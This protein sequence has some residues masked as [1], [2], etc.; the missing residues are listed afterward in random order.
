MNTDGKFSDVSAI[1]QTAFLSHTDA[2]AEC[3]QCAV[4]RD[5]SKPKRPE[6]SAATV[7]DGRVCAMKVFV[8]SVRRG[9]EA[10][11][12]SLPG[13]LSAIGHEPV[14]FE[15]FTAQPVPSREACLRAVAASDVYLLLLG[16]RY[17]HV[18][19]D[20]GQS[21]THDEWVAAR[22]KGMPTIV[23]RKVGVKFEPEQEQFTREV[24]DYGTGVFYREF[25]TAVDLQRKVV[26]ALSDLATATSPLTFEPLTGPSGIDWGSAQPDRGYD[27][28]DPSLVVHVRPLPATRIPNRLLDQLPERLVAAVRDA[29]I[30]SQSV[31]LVPSSDG[32]GAV[33][34][35]WPRTPTRRALNGVSASEI[36]SVRGNADGEVAVAWTLPGDGLGAILNE[37]DLATSIAAA[38]KSVGATR[39]VTSS[40]VVIGAELRGLSMVSEAP[41]TGI[42]RQSAS[43]G[44]R[45]PRTV[46]VEPDESVSDAAL[47]VGADEVASMTARALITRFR[48]GS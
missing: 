9:L 48:Q 25:E 19:L 18:F 13:L 23:F 42:A 39:L 31:G 14:R 47:S 35:S 28:S 15:D 11:R 24:G 6:I 36:V 7:G 44:H 32:D 46:Q 37:N 41:I 43:M 22:S 8:S 27:Y 12:D 40:R 29:S 34:V 10:E 38:L 2:G 45:A 5:V 26:E 1:T 16:P 21:A 3:L 30:V 17:G 20:T 4:A 33:L